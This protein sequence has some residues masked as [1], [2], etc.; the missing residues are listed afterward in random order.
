M[1]NIYAVLLAISI[2]LNW[3]LVWKCFQFKNE[4]DSLD[5]ILRSLVFPAHH[6]KQK[7]DFH[8]EANLTP[9]WVEDEMSR[10]IQ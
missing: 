10:K 8:S 5:S 7:P 6:L 4:S 1:E 9:Q 2:L 3:F